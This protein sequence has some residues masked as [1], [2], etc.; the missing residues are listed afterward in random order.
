MYNSTT[1]Q[2][3]EEKCS[4]DGTIY[5]YREEKMTFTLVYENDLLDNYYL[6]YKIVAYDISGYSVTVNS[7]FALTASIAQVPLKAESVI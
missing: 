1:N 5:D 7:L 6:N 4:F 2:A 3:T